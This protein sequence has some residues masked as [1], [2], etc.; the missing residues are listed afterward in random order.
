VCGEI[1]QIVAYDGS[2]CDG[3]IE[4]AVSV[5]IAMI[6][7][8]AGKRVRHPCRGEFEDDLR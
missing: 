7:A 2:V 3:C 5:E 1:G 4:S 6:T 8:W